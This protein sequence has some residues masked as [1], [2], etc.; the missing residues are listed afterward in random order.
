MK[1]LNSSSLT[2]NY[3]SRLSFTA[4]IFAFIIHNTEE[5]IFICRFPVQSPV[6]FIEP[7]SCRQ[8][9]WAVS[10]LTFVEIIVSILALTTKKPAVYLFIS[11]ALAAP[12]LFNVLMPH[13]SIALYTFHYTPG[14]ASAIILILPL[15]MIVLVKNRK[16][17]S[18]K[19]QFIK[20]ILIGFIIGY[21]FFTIIMRVVFLFIN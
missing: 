14:L 3:N 10:I 6:L 9:L 20:H 1:V 21:L 15:S 11:T 16:Q 13:L 17:Y 2:S 7:A 5:A 4:L 18:T 19:S 12:L 8:F